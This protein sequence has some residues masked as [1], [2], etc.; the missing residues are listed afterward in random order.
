V[1]SELL[2]DIINESIEKGVMPRAVK[3]ELK[4]ATLIPIHMPV[5][6]FFLEII[7]INQLTQYIEN[8]N[9]LIKQQSGFR[10]NHS[11]E[12]SLNVVLKRWKE[13][14]DENKLIVPAFL[15]LNR[16]FETIDRNILM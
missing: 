16:A 3:G 15:D 8:E 5:P 10:R 1:L 7:V 2:T 6:D 4:G 13:E 12:T 11:C 14:I 9:I